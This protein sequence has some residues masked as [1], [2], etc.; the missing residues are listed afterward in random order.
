MR[1]VCRNHR[2]RAGSPAKPCRGQ[3]E[4]LRMRPFD[5][6]NP[7]TISDA[8]PAAAQPG[9]A[10]L[11]GGTNLLDLMKG[12]IARPD[13]LVDVAQLP[14]LDRIEHLADGGLRIGALV[15]NADLAHDFDFAKSYPAVAEAL[16]SGASA[17]LRNAAT[18]GGNLL[19]RT[20]C[21]YFYDSASACHKRQPRTGCDALG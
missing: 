5:S 9:P 1:R 7:A 10:Y 14:G 15:R 21:G 13:R 17:Q 12:G 4:A 11:A 3:S 20:R 16:L 8:V 19:Q 2:R 6:P 18:V